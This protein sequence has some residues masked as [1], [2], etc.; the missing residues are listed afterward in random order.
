MWVTILPPLLNAI[1]GWWIIAH[2]RT[3][4]WH[5]PLMSMILSLLICGKEL[6][7]WSLTL[8]VIFSSPPPSNWIWLFCSL[9]PPLLL[10]LYLQTLIIYHFP[11]HYISISIPYTLQPP[12]DLIILLSTTNTSPFILPPYYVYLNNCFSFPFF[13]PF[14]SDYN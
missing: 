2:S 1:K 7:I 3:R 8:E 13:T 6:Y 11:P 10:F 4:S 14:N 12:L 5:S 9:P